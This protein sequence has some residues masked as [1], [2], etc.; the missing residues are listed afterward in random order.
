MMPSFWISRVRAVGKNVPIAEVSF[1]Q[2]LNVIS[3]ASDSGKSYILQCINYMLGAENP[4]K[5]VEEDAGYD[6]LLM[7]LVTGAKKN[8]VL[9]RSLKQGGDFLLYEQGLDKDLV[10]KNGT[11]LARKHNPK[12]TDTV[13]AFLLGL[14]DLQE[15]TIKTKATAT[16]SLSFRDICRF[17]IINEEGIISEESP[18]Y[19]SRNLIKRTENKS[20][21]D[22]M[23][24]GEDASSVIVAPDLQVQRAGWR[25]RMELY[26]ELIRDIELEIPD[27]HDNLGSRLKKLDGRMSELTA[28]V[29]ANSSEIAKAQSQRVDAWKT[30]HKAVSRQLVVNDLLTRF[31]VLGDHYRSDIDR[32]GFLAEGDHYIAQLGGD[33]HCPIC[34]SLLDDHD[35]RHQ[36]SED[37]DETIQSAAHAEIAKLNLLLTDLDS[38]MNGLQAELTQLEQDVSELDRTI[39]GI[40][41]RLQTQLAPHVQAT[42]SEIDQLF[43]ARNEVVAGMVSRSRLELLIQQRQD[44]GPE[45]KRAKAT[46]IVPATAS[47]T[48]GRRAFCNR[49]QSLLKRWRYPQ[50]GIVEFNE[51]MDLVVA[52]KPRRSHGKG[53]RAILQSAFTV[54]LMLHGK[55][56]HPGFV[57]LDS[58]LTSFRPND[59][60]EIDQDVQHG[61]FEYLS[62]L[63]EGQI[64]VLENKEPPESLQAKMHY[65]HFAGED[66]EGREGFYP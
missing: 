29:A 22:F 50:N 55:A 45:P 17:A 51:E 5:S 64:I 32:L 28:I 53:I 13:S 27:T 66:G 8:Y 56:R 25:A 44:L 30:K 9:Q 38:T 20:V 3:G 59:R 33:V 48:A 19:P 61:F 35:A 12:K 6:T 31:K 57:V 10:K 1:S 14:C 40:D 21:F 43:N 11:H 41:G 24:S 49:L 7:E 23:V 39:E 52:G 26:D 60:Y 2:Y 65:E 63:R 34:G 62:S 42:M 4:P 16:R 36:V 54:T 18:V 46:T 58:P 47:E 15:T 37:G